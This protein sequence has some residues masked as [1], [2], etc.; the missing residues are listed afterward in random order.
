MNLG[1]RIRVIR[2]SRR[3]TQQQLA[4]QAGVSRQTISIIE[5]GSMVPS[6]LVALQLS[7]VLKC[8]V[9]EIFSLE[10]Q[11]TPVWAEV[12]KVTCPLPV[13]LAKLDGILWAWPLADEGPVQAADAIWYPDGGFVRLRERSPAQ[14][15]VLLGCHPGINLLEGYLQRRGDPIKSIIRVRNS[16]RAAE[17]LLEHKAHAAGVHLY[18]TLSR[19][20]NFTIA[21]ETFKVEGGMLIHF[22]RWEEGLCFR[23]ENHIEGMSDPAFRTMRLVGRE[24]GSEA[25]NLLNRHLAAVDRNRVNTVQLVARSHAQVAKVV[26][27]GLGDAGV[28][29]RYEAE[30]RGLGFLPLA[31]ESFDLMVPARFFKTPPVQALLEVLADEHFRAE[32]NMLRSDAGRSGEVLWSTG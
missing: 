25:H 7:R 15:L 32:M 4:D 18:D 5:G 8:S 14:T 24:E 26:Q 6:V 10:E 17:G 20:Y 27:D 11:D 22:A 1:N 9:E 21:K 23:P 28:T 30:V 16:L 3:L 29:V 2:Q 31:E 13:S 12:P 19:S